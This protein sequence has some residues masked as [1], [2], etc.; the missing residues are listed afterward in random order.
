MERK[1]M[2]GMVHEKRV[3][4]TFITLLFKFRTKEANVNASNPFQ[5]QLKKTNNKPADY[6]GKEPTTSF[7]QSEP[8][9]AEYSDVKLKKTNQ[10]N[11]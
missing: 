3:R 1:P 2:L 9:K 4:E 8:A 7:K 5:V 10:P 11:A 6:D